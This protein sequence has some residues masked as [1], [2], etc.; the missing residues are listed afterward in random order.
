[1]VMPDR[2]YLFSVPHRTPEGYRAWADVLRPHLTR[3][4]QS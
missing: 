1:M 2:F 3:A 4:V